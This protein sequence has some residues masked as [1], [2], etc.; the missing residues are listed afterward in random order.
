[1]DLTGSILEGIRV[2]ELAQNAAIPHCG[3]L[4]AGLGADVVK[5]EPP[6]GDAMRGLA[7]LGP[8]E[9]GVVLGA[10]QL[11]VA[12]HG[13]QTLGDVEAL[14]AGDRLLLGDFL[15][16]ANEW[17]PV[18]AGAKV[19]AVPEPCGLF[20]VMAILPLIVCRRREATKTQLMHQYDS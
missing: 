11:H 18:G 17:D 9:G 14:A 16:L 19:A 10:D 2:L 7:Q 20:G 3:R 8:R 15:T 13:R 6:D 12:A 1:M 5:V 4:L